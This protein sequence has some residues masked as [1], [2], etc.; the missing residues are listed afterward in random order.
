VPQATPGRPDTVRVELRC[1]DP[2]CNPYLAF[3]IMLRAGLDGVARELEPPPISNENLYHLDDME[4]QAR[5]LQT[6]PGRW[7]RRWRS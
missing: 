2:S 1:P 6:L 3:A 5:K 4:R 7:A